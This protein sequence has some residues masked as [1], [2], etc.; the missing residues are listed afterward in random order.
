MSYF[1]GYANRKGVVRL[2]AFTGHTRAD[3]PFNIELSDAGISVHR[4]KGDAL[5]L[6]RA[7][8]LYAGDAFVSN[9]LFAD[10]VADVLADENARIQKHSSEL[11][12]IRDELL[13]ARYV[14]G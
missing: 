7:I 11:F 12:K 3:F 9:E 14:D 8:W 1:D 10:A 5:E 2:V 13:K 6:C 4:I